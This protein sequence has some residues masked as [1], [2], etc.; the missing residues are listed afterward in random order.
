M[1]K[2]NQTD[3][4]VPDTQLTNLSRQELMKELQRR[5]RSADDIMNKKNLSGPELE[6]LFTLNEG[7]AMGGSVNKKRIGAN[8]YRKG[9]YVLSTMDNRKVKRNGK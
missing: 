1:A 9:G 7:M 2:D 6:A 5:G 4:G 8:D 3:A